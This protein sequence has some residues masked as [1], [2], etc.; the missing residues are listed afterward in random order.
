MGSPVA[1]AAG[2]R[3]GADLV[4]NCRGKVSSQVIYSERRG[5]KDSLV[6]DKEAAC[7]GQRG[8]PGS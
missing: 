8:S 7:G 1:L 5:G 3:L 2:V 4:N 6:S